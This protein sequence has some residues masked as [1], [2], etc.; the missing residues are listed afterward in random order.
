M[1]I[2]YEHTELRCLV[3]GLTKEE[4]RNIFVTSLD[5]NPRISAE[6]YRSMLTWEISLYHNL[7]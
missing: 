6:P 3:E 7:S 5:Q 4:E 1:K 2:E